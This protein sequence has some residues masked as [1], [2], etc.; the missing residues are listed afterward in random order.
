V[1]TCPACVTA[2]GDAVVAIDSGGFAGVLV[3]LQV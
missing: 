2:D 1:I 3:M